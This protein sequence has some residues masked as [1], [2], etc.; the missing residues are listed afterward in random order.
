VSFFGVT[1]HHSTTSIMVLLGIRPIVLFAAL[2]AQPS[3]FLVDAKKE[4]EGEKKDE[5]NKMQNLLLSR[6]SR[7]KGERPGG[8]NKKLEEPLEENEESIKDRRKRSNNFLPGGEEPLFAASAFEKAFEKP[9]KKLNPRPR[10]GGGG[11]VA[12][13]RA[14]AKAAEPAV[15][16]QQNDDEI[17][18]ASSVECDLHQ[19]DDTPFGSI[20]GPDETCVPN[21][22]SS[23]GGICVKATAAIQNARRKAQE[24][25]SA[26]P[27]T[28]PPKEG[29]PVDAVYYRSYGNY[30]YGENYCGLYGIEDL[31]VKEASLSEDDYLAYFPFGYVNFNDRLFCYDGLYSADGNSADGSS[32]DVCFEQ[33]CIRKVATFFYSYFNP[34]PQYSKRA[35]EIYINDDSCDSCEVVY[36]DS[37]TTA[38]AFDCS[39][40]DLG[41][42]EDDPC[43]GNS[44]FES[45]EDACKDK[46]DDKMKGDKMKGDKEKGDK[47]KGDKKEGGKRVRTHH[48]ELI[49]LYVWFERR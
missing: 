42:S 5:K 15:P 39:N 37:Y 10:A 31:C 22:A 49:G 11:G 40:T 33:V 29:P 19:Q 32:G 7:A 13:L 35:C 25:C 28:K 36:C 34:F 26:N 6:R 20:C 44:L 4:E 3:L 2:A 18:P 24:A 27:P 12:G 48:S 8:D 9:K 45:I 46:E 1:H 21:E 23:L 16:I 14:K 41:T 47:M 30:C 17:D 43:K 38:L